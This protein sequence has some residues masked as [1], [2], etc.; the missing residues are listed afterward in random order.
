MLLGFKDTYFFHSNALLNYIK[1]HFLHFQ[2]CIISSLHL[3]ASAPSVKFHKLLGPPVKKYDH[4]WLWSVRP[5]L[6]A[7]LSISSD[8]NTET[9]WTSRRPPV[10]DQVTVKVSAA[11][12]PPATGDVSLHTCRSQNYWW[13]EASEVRDRGGGVRQEMHRPPTWRWGFPKAEVAWASPFLR[14]LC[15]SAA[16]L[17]TST[18][19]VQLC[20]CGE[21][22]VVEPRQL[23]STQSQKGCKGVAD[24]NRKTKWP[25]HNVIRKVVQLEKGRGILSF[26]EGD[27]MNFLTL[28]IE[29][30]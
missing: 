30:S 27:W 1:P 26:V 23:I 25:T 3:S 28:S 2:W 24:R 14:R 22:G 4:P 7:H 20:A 8:G 13:T 21:V 11:T 9:T 29:G 10:P 5:V 15:S 6:T 18:R 12:P 19:A 16:A 17:L